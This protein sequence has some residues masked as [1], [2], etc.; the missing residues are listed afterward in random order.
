MPSACYGERACPLNVLSAPMGAEGRF[1]T[2]VRSTLQAW[3]DA[4][5]A[6]MEGA[7]IRHDEARARAV[8]GVSLVQ[9]SLVVS[10]GL[11]TTAPFQAALISLPDMLL[12]Q[13]G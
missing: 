9:G 7:G 13:N 2:A 4:L 5:A 8:Q 12:R 11:G 3:I 10:R 1:A 6:C